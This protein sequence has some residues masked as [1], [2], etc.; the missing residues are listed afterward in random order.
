MNLVPNL[1][2]DNLVLPRLLR[3]LDRFKIASILSKEHSKGIGDE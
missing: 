1:S 2:F 3:S